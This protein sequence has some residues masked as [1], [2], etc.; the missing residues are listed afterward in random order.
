MTRSAASA[1]RLLATLALVAAI[2]VLA[3]SVLAGS[4]SAAPRDDVGGVGDDIVVV[5]DPDDPTETPLSQLDPSRL[6][7]V[8]IPSVSPV[9]TPDPFD[10]EVG[11]STR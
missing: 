4:V 5:D 8:A 2:V 3:A 11:T 9:P 1:L 10:V 6:T 7:P